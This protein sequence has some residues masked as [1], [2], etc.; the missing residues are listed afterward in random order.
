MG[1][2]CLLGTKHP[3][4]NTFPSVALISLPYC[5]RFTLNNAHAS[6]LVKETN[7]FHY[8][9]SYIWP[10]WPIIWDATFFIACSYSLP[11]FIVHCSSLIDWSFLGLDWRFICL[12]PLSFWWHYGVTKKNERSKWRW[13]ILSFQNMKISIKFIMECSTLLALAWFN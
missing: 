1:K 5:T 2:H 3:F 13:S 8:V 11:E 7:R 6:G 4:S 12:W 9:C 10:L